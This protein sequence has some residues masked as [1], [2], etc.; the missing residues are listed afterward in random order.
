[1]SRCNGTIDHI[2]A[3]RRLAV[4]DVPAVVA[5]IRGLPDYFTDDVPAKVE[6]DAV[7]HDAWVVTDSGTV[8][9]FA[10][11]ARKSPGGAEILWLAVDAAGRGR[12]Q[13][14]LLL[15]R[16]L[17]SLAD[18]GVAV[19]A[20]KTLDASSGYRPYE[21]TRAFWERNGFVQI[22]TIDP[23]PG[24]QPGNPAAIYVAAIRATR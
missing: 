21:P 15:S 16:V 11:V 14:T 17:D 6:H 8:A 19:V 12:G 3:V 20:A 9:G 13:G 4:A 5:I 18:A 1:M 22:D 23:L 10:V 2:L 7:N 24:W